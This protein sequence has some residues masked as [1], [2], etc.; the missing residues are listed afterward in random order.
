MKELPVLNY[1]VYEKILEKVVEL[2]VADLEKFISLRGVKWTKC[3]NDCHN[4]QSFYAI[5][6][7][8]PLF[9]FSK[10]ISDTEQ[11]LETSFVA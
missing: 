6:V 1:D 7:S 5:G 9:I 11:V 10:L 4:I 8:R 2:E 3:K